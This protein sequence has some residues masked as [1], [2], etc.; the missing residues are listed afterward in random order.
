MILSATWK[1]SVVS[2]KQKSTPKQSK[3]DPKNL[4]DS[5]AIYRG[6]Y[7]DE[8]IEMFEINKLSG[9]LE[10]FEEFRSKIESGDYRGLRIDPRDFMDM[11]KAVIIPKEGDA[12][13]HITK[14]DGKGI[15][16]KPIRDL[17]ARRIGGIGDLFKEIMT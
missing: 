3:P 14:N 16:A 15:T 12:M 1:V 11:S 8:I 7:L 5:F 4:E 2:A 17:F 6:P 10:S 13:F 9:G